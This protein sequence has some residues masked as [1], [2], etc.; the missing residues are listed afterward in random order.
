MVEVNGLTKYYGEYTAI[1]DVSF[2]VAPG[3]ILGFLGPNAA[4]KTTTMRILTG[5]MPPTAG[6]AVVDGVDVVQ[7]SVEARKRL[8][9]LPEQVPLYEDMSVREY[10][11]Y[12]AAIRGVPRKSIAERVDKVMQDT[13]VTEYADALIHKLSKGYRQRVGIAQALV[14]EPKI[15]ILDEPTVGLDPRQIK[16]VR[17]LIRSLRGEH[18]VIL[19]THILPEVQMVCD[20]VVIINEGRV[21]AEDTPESLMQRLQGRQ[22]VRVEVRGPEKEV[23]GT[24]RSLPGVTRVQVEE[25]EGD[26][27]AFTIEAQ[28][29]RDIRESVAAAVVRRGWGL[30]ELSSVSLSLEDV[31]IR[32]TT[33]EAAEESASNDETPTGDGARAQGIR[34]EG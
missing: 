30:R 23:A 29:D 22:Q 20:R 18:T 5:F 27:R 17:E 21:V 1:E 19:S 12:C 3:E 6:T 31:Y 2:R 14:H 25:S 9:Y 24:L 10:L 4:G 33:G 32:L 13:A 34:K 28:R 15:L 8:G 7:D 11:G 26:V 16:E